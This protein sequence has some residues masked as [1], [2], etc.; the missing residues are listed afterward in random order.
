MDSINMMLKAIKA[1]ISAILSELQDTY[2]NSLIEEPLTSGKSIKV[3]KLS[4]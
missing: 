3:S 2:T 1:S 4:N